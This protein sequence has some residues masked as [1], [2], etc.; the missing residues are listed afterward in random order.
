MLAVRADFA[1]AKPRL[2]RALV[3]AIARAERLIHADKRAAADAVMRALPTASID[4]KHLDVLIDVYEPA[5]PPTPEVSADAIAPALAL[6]PANKVPPR[7]DGIDLRRYVLP[8]FAHEAN[9]R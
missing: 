2:V 4:R 5:V 7:L 1:A 6:Y 3:R 8:R 9:K